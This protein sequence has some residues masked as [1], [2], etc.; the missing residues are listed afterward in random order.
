MNISIRIVDISNSPG[1]IGPI[2]CS[3]LLAAVKCKFM[4]ILCGY[5]EYNLYSLPGFWG[6]L[7]SSLSSYSL[8]HNFMG[9]LYYRDFYVRHKNRLKG[10][11]S[12]A[13]YKE[14][15]TKRG[16]KTFYK[17]GAWKKSFYKNRIVLTP[18]PHP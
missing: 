4:E 8:T 1:R 13:L 7:S 10:T 12:W 11:V 9:A 3:N 6:R 15:L 17:Y 18:P 2:S 14:S 5:V 16:L